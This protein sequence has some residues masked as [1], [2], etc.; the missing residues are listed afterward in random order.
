MFSYRDITSY[1]SFLKDHPDGCKQTVLHYLAVIEKNKKLN[2]FV[3]IFAEESISRAEELDQKRVSG[4]PTG[5]LHGVVIAIKDVIC[6][7][8]HPVTA[9]SKMLENFIS[10]YN[11][12]AVIRMLDED[13]II[14]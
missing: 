3:N 4:E 11:S 6:Y 2:A 1:F 8:D 7:K 12:T 13:A 9:A 14:I 10:V 5:K